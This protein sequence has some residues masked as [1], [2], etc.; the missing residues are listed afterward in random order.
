M[1]SLSLSTRVYPSTRA[2]RI[3]LLLPIVCHARPEPLGHTPSTR[4]VSK[5]HGYGA[6]LFARSVRSIYLQVH[7][8]LLELLPDDLARRESLSDSHHR[9]IFVMEVPPSWTTTVAPASPLEDVEGEEEEEEEEK[10]KAY[11]AFKRPMVW[12][13]HHRTIIRAMLS[14]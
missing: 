5:K 7:L 6:A 9:L 4:S 8:R 3:S 1:S 2:D 11:E 10:T 13:T 12:T 14:L